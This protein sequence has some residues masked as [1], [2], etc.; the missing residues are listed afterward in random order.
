M[1][2]RSANLA[3]YGVDFARARLKFDGVTLEY[4]DQRRAYGESRI[5]AFGSVDNDVF[6][7]VY[8]WRGKSR[9]LISARRAGSHEREAYREA[10]RQG[11]RN[12]K[13]E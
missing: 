5:G 10:L 1:E 8:T 6:F 12:E 2:K 3:K 11:G 13:S 4:P 9:R 7:V